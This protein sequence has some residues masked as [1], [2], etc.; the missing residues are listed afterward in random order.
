MRKRGKKLLAIML[1]ASMTLGQGSTW[2]LAQEEVAETI[3]GA[4]LNAQAEEAGAEEIGDE[5]GQ[6]TPSGDSE[7]TPTPGEEETG[8]SESDN[9]SENNQGTGDNSSENP[10]EDT[11]QGTGDDSG[12]SDETDGG[13]TSDGNGNQDVDQENPDGITDG[14]QKGETSENGKTDF[15]YEDAKIIIDA[16][17]TAEAGFKEDTVL[18]ADYLDPEG[19]DEQKAAYQNAVEII[20]QQLGETLTNN[21]E[22]ATLD[23]VLYDVYFESQTGERLEPAEGTVEVTMSFKEPV[24]LETKDPETNEQNYELLNQEVV[25]IQQ[26]ENDTKTAELVQNSNIQ[27]ENDQITSATF[28]QDSF[29]VMGLVWAKAAV[30]S[31]S[32][33]SSAK[34]KSVQLVTGEDGT[35]FGHGIETGSGTTDDICW[36]PATD[37]NK[38][39]DN[40]IDNNI[41]RSFDS[42]RYY[43][44]AAFDIDKKAH[45]LVLEVTL[46]DDNEITIDQKASGI[47]A[48]TKKDGTNTYICEYDVPAEYS[49]GEQ[50]NP[51]VIKVGNKHQGDIIQPIIKAYFDDDSNNAVQIENIPEVIVTTAPLY[52]I[53]LAKKS[54]KAIELDS[55]DFG[56]TSTDTRAHYYPEYAGND[57]KKVTGY[58]CTFGI[59]LE[60]RKLGEGIKG[61]EFPDPGEDFTFDIDLSNVTTADGRN[62]IDEGFIPRLY[63]TGPN[64]NGGDAITEI[65]FTA[66]SDK[67]DSTDKNYCNNSGNFTMTQSSD[68]KTLHVTVNGFTVNP[69][70]FPD[71]NAKGDSYWENNKNAILELRNL[72]IFIFIQ[73]DLK[74]DLMEYYSSIEE[75]IWENLI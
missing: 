2:T 27:I 58:E 25:H 54:G 41:I 43:V 4:A 12:F 18:K 35:I 71:C 14:E 75:S 53:V 1:A 40:A 47:A 20:R 56:K 19:T 66:E 22:E 17:A 72:E 26:N 34:V 62:L 64:Q 42:I 36:N 28:T 60:M 7:N 8:G 52:N 32:N 57:S 69:S 68:G 55:F 37:T 30:Q 15:H 44:K 33:D 59:A 11:N 21:N 29:S 9:S 67:G 49:G 16:K 61:I 70:E 73:K 23:Y 31:A 13:D 39:Y 45:K 65:P 10:S 51:L 48:L 6:D 3:E 74:M 5:G 63:Y 38:G 46:P 24:K 50:T